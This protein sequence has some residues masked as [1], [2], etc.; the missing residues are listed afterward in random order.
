[1]MGVGYIV[2]NLRLVPAWRCSYAC[3]CCHSTSACEQCAHP[4]VSHLSRS[5]SKSLLAGGSWPNPHPR[6]SA[7]ENHLRT[8][9]HLNLR[10]GGVDCKQVCY[11]WLHRVMLCWVFC[12]SRVWFQQ[13]KVRRRLYSSTARCPGRR[14]IP[15]AVV[16]RESVTQVHHSEGD[17][18]PLS[19]V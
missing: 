15:A 17:V 2:R 14:L 9:R 12:Q 8:E 1:M 7:S 5:S 6:C 11:M 19:P 16:R 4:S 18:Q 10:G 3:M 13:L